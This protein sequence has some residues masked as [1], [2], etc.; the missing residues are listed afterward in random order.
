MDAVFCLGQSF[1]LNGLICGP[2]TQSFVPSRMQLLA[3][4]DQIMRK[5]SFPTP[6]MVTF[7]MNNV[8]AMQKDYVVSPTGEYIAL[9]SCLQDYGVYSTPRFVEYLARPP[10]MRV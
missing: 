2:I 4:P 1:Q 3:T 5:F 9:T 10:Y 8:L 7:S 6:K